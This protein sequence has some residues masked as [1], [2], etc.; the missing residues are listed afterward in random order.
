MEQSVTAAV[1]RATT[2]ETAQEEVVPPTREVII[3]VAEEEE[4]ATMQTGMPR[5]TNRHRLRMESASSA[6]TLATLL[7]CAPARAATVAEVEVVVVVAVITIAVAI[8]S[9]AAWTGEPIGSVVVTGEAGSKGQGDLLDQFTQD[10]KQ[11]AGNNF[12]TNDSDQ[13]TDEMTGRTDLLLLPDMSVQSVVRSRT[14]LVPVPLLVATDDHLQTMKNT[15]VAMTD[16][17][18]NATRGTGNTKIES[19][20]FSTTK[21]RNSVCAKRLYYMVPTLTT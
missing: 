21:S 20:S 5:T 1:R 17:L 16:L 15:V 6:D 3:V 11:V 10:L 7:D 13:V 12:V 4:T 14:A 2:Q 19:R 9:A 18:M 8:G